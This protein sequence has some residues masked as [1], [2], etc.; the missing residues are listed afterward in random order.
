MAK[1][2]PLFPY[3]IAR[4]ASDSRYHA[5]E[6]KTSAEHLS[7][8]HT[9]QTA[10]DASDDRQSRLDTL[11]A[12]AVPPSQIVPQSNVRIWCLKWCA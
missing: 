10:F 2:F 9:C 8:C 5:D 1:A 3:T 12:P 4:S 11:S 7:A 6:R